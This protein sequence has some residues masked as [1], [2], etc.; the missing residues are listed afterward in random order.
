M[1]KENYPNTD[2]HPAPGTAEFFRVPD[3][4]CVSV[5]NHESVQMHRWPDGTALEREG[6]PDVQKEDERMA[7]TS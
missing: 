2:L 6:N 4:R 5:Y 1:Y 7:E 3:A